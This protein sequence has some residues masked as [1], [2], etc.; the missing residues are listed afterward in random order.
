MLDAAVLGAAELRGHACDR[1]TNVTTASGS[2]PRVTVVALE[3]HFVTSATAPR[4]SVTFVRSVGHG[5]H[6]HPQTPTAPGPFTLHQQT[7]HTLV[8]PRDKGATN[9]RGR[10]DLNKR[11]TNP[12]KLVSVVFSAPELMISTQTAAAIRLTSTIR[13]PCRDRTRAPRTITTTPSTSPSGGSA[14]ARM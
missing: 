2:R 11:P 12:Q 3:A 8:A 1:R 14:T 13:S 4:A 10:P 9:A 7:F 6:Y 5:A